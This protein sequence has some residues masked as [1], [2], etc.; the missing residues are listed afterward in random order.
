MAWV[1]GAERQPTLY[2]STNLCCPSTLLRVGAQ[3]VGLDLTREREREREEEERGGVNE[4]R[5]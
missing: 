4:V 2:Q 3:R 5:G 1:G